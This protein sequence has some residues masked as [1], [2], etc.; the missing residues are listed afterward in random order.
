M[1]SFS[2]YLQGIGLIGPGFINWTQGLAILAGQ[3][4]YQIQKTVLSPPASL[5]AAERRRASPLV[6]A[7]LEAGHEA[8][9]MAGVSPADPASVFASSGGDGHICNAIC[10]A[11]ASG[12]SMISPTQ[13]HNSVHNAVSG[14]WSI[15]A[16]AM[17][18][19]SVIS[20]HDGSFAAGLLEAMMLLAS[21]QR[22]VLFIACDSDYPQPL[23]DARPIP[24]TFAVAL[25]L[26]ATS[27]YGKTIAE[28]NF[29]EDALFTRATVQSMD[30]LVLESLR[31][32]IPAARC[33]PLL[34]A[35]ATKK[36]ECVVLDYVDKTNLAVDVVPCG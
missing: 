1:K 34:Q 5:P 33:L 8:C 28:L 30:D 29:R 6:M 20:A 31:Q 36:A 16:R 24:D 13:F 11:L 23:H 15:A 7:A 21:D 10:S 2:A 22:P 4:P 14:Y 3:K 12:E 26:T 18:P 32:S 17:T 35:I 27:R 9:T 25:L 19:S